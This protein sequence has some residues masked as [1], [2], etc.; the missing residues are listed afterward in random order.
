MGWLPVKGV[1][2]PQSQPGGRRGFG[3]RV[4]NGWR[5]GGLLCKAAPRSGENGGAKTPHGS[6]WGVW[7]RRRIGQED[8]IA[9]P[10]PRAG[11]T[12]TEPAAL[13]DQMEIG[14]H[15]ACISAAAKGELG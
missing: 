11:A 15:L 12:L 4:R 3:I 7:P 8:L 2:S 9:R 5:C 13:I 1:R 10:E 14:Q 6:G